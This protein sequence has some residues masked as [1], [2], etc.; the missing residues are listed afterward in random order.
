MVAHL[1]LTFPK[2]SKSHKV[3]AKL[4]HPTDST[5]QSVFQLKKDDGMK[6]WASKLHLSVLHFCHREFVIRMDL[7]HY[8]WKHSIRRI[9]LIQAVNR[10]RAL[11]HK[12]QQHTCEQG[13]WHA[14]YCMLQTHTNFLP[15][16]SLFA[17]HMVYK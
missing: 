1:I 14:A 6:Y 16:S 2:L 10:H 12:L 15:L 4:Q 3:F 8:I 9:V 11:H 5:V 7:F 13:Y 17:E